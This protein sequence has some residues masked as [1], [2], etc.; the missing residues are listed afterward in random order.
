MPT[1]EELQASGEIMEFDRTLAFFDGPEMVATAGIFSY[2][3][4]VPGGR[5]ACAGVTRVTVRSTHRRRG[6]LTA[7]MRRQL[8][9][10]HQRGEPLAA[11]YA[12]E[13]P[14]YG[15]FGYGLATYEASLEVSR[16]HAPFAR[17]LSGN[18]RLL[19]V[20]VPAAVSPFTRDLG[21]GASH[22]A[23]HAGAG[24]ALDPRPLTRP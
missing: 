18:G 11:L 12:S 24:R 3:M 16:P 17:R 6:L 5:L 20:D 1:D 8:D 2:E 19:M 14:I 10:M 9:D 21:R 22:P 13:A 4:T 7:M 15:R 23:R